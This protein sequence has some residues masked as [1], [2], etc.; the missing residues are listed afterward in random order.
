MTEQAPPD[1][2][3]RHSRAGREILEEQNITGSGRPC[4]QNDCSEAPNH[5]KITSASSRWPSAAGIGSGMLLGTFLGSGDVVGVRCGRH[6]RG[7]D[8]F[9]SILS[10]AQAK[11]PNCTPEVIFSCLTTF[12]RSQFLSSLLV[13]NYYRELC[14][15]DRGFSRNLYKIQKNDIEHF[16]KRNRQISEFPSRLA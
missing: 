3:G 14:F 10:G 15:K 11:C 1:G 2:R 5:E 9:R 13:Y 8:S 6:G 4:T 12:G 7:I 16:G